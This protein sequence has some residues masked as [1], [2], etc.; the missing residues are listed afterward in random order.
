MN[1]LQ[2]KNWKDSKEALGNK[3]YQVGD[4]FFHTTSLPLVGKTVGYMP[5]PDLNKINWEDLYK[6]AKE[7]KCVYITIDPDNK[8]NDSINLPTNFKFTDGQAVHLS[9]TLMIS[10]E[11]SEDELLADMKQKHRYNLNLATKK[12]VTTKISNDE[13]AFAE[14]IKLYESTVLR[15]GYHGRSSNYL[16]TVWDH[17]KSENAFISTAYFE[18]IPIVSWFVISYEDTLTYVYGGSSDEHKNV[19]APFLLEWELV[20]LGKNHGYK[21]LDLFGIKS[22]GIDRSGEVQYDGYSRFKVGFGGEIVDYYKTL[23]FIIEPK[24]Y[25]LVKLAANLR[26]KIIFK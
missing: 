14:F 17:F 9:Q 6:A 2:S 19:M 25:N 10:L 16:K 20:K 21:Y 3:T 26:S 24:I 4:Y 18:N 1:F 5:R 13:N 12:G 11:R 23:D 15:Q 22:T 7:A 8:A